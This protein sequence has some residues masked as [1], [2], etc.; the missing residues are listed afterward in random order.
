MYP[1]AGY[2]AGEERCTLRTAGTVVVSFV[3]SILSFCKIRIMRVQEDSS[4]VLHFKKSS[5]MSNDEL[6]ASKSFYVV[7]N[8]DISS[9]RVRKL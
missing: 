3:D 7:F 4:F 1:M 8:R 6:R 5:G 2:T 9:K